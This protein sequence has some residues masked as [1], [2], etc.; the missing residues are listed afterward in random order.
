MPAWRLHPAGPRLPDS[1]PE[2]RPDPKFTSKHTPTTRSEEKK[3]LGAFF[4]F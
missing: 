4:L 3:L 2:M 1:G